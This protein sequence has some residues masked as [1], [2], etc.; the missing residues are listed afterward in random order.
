MGVFGG[1][2][3]GLAYAKEHLRF[4][5]PVS[6]FEM[7]ICLYSFGFQVFAAQNLSKNE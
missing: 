4:S 2:L 7:L 3:G 1:R 6:F 5:K